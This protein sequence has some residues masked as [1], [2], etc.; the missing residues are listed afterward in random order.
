MPEFTQ[1]SQY[2]ICSAILLVICIS[3]TGEKQSP[4][5]FVQQL[6]QFHPEEI[7]RFQKANSV[8]FSHI[9]YETISLEDETILLPLRKPEILIQVNPKGD[10]IEMIARQGRGPGEVRDVVFTNMK[11]NGG[12][13]VY[14]QGNNKILRFDQKGEFIGEFIPKPFESSSIEG[15][16][17]TKISDEYLVL[18]ESHAFL[19]D[20]TRRP[21]LYLIRY[22]AES[23]TYG[24]RL[25]LSD[26]RVARLVIDDQVRGGREVHYTP[27]HLTAWDSESKTLYTYWTGSSQVAEVSA[28]FDTLRTIPINLPSQLLSSAERDSIEEDVQ[29]TQWKTLGDLLPD[30]KTSIEKMKL[31]QKGCFWLKLNYRGDTDKW[32]VMDREG[33]FEKIVHLPRGSMLTHISD[34]HLGVRLD[35]ITFALYEPV[36]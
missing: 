29:P 15:F 11:E 22:D 33:E 13:L 35:E 19:F 24:K 20:K 34:N 6:P 10:L 17:P 18:F 28:N 31:D 21:V 5:E 36:E 2:G 7:N 27:D 26:R 3:C 25:T 14:D 23:E 16:Y 30:R 1:R 9:S 8:Y 32:L 4:K 12:V